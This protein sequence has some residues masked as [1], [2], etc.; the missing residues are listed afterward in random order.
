MIQN[1]AVDDR[2]RSEIG[3]LLVTADPLR[4]RV[5][6]QAGHWVYVQVVRLTRAIASVGH[7][8]AIL[9]K[10]AIV[11]HAQVLQSVVTGVA[12]GIEHGVQFRMNR[13]PGAADLAV[14]PAANAAKG[15]S[16]ISFIFGHIAPFA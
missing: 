4:A 2:A 9:F 6:E 16:D 8:R 1:N 14:E 15:V 3:T 12:T 7:D 11:V 10:M 5:H 13:F